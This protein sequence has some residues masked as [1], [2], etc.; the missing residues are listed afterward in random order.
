MRPGFLPSLLAGVFFPAL[1]A[2]AGAG[3]FPLLPQRPPSG[4]KGQEQ[5]P[6]PPGLRGRPLRFPLPGQAPG[7]A[8]LP[9]LPI[10]GPKGTAP[11]LGTGLGLWEALVAMSKQEEGGKS[12]ELGSVPDRSLL[13]RYSD[14]VGVRGKGERG[15]EVLPWWRKVRVLEP[16]YQVDLSHRGRALQIL[17]DGA[18]LDV[19]APSRW[20]V[21]RLDRGIA[22]FRFQSLRSLFAEAAQRLVRLILPGGYALDLQG[23]QVTIRF[24][25]GRFRVANLGPKAVVIHDKKKEINLAWNEGCLLPVFAGP[26]P[27]AIPALGGEGERIRALGKG[28]L[29]LSWTESLDAK[30]GGETWI[31]GAR[32][33][34][35]RVRWGGC[36]F[37]LSKG[38]S[39]KIRPF[40]Q[41][42]F[43]VIREEAGVENASLGKKGK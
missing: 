41:L 19:R 39:L 10:V 11:R 1:A 24:E 4:R 28:T 42:P 18:V 22:L 9:T 23:G 40:R 37:D 16:G 2:G 36:A 14:L 21:A 43:K 29:G 34:G 3:Q 15:W 25:R 8:G 35:G 6:R 38:Q 30:G 7:A 32:Q 33:A 27:P 13:L 5:N 17:Y 26:P 20:E 31:F 12:L